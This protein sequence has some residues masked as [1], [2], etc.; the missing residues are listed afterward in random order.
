MLFV[1]YLSRD[2]PLYQNTRKLILS[3][4]NPYFFKVFLLYPSPC[5]INNYTNTFLYVFL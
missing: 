2:D 1:G 4:Y 5:I 3:E